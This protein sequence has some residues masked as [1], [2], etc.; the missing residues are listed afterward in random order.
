MNDTDYW[1]G[2][3]SDTNGGHTYHWVDGSTLSYLTYNNWGNNLMGK[4]EIMH[5]LF[6]S[7]VAVCMYVKV[8]NFWPCRDSQFTYISPRQVVHVVVVVVNDDIEFQ[9]YVAFPF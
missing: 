6:L 4:F 3:R 7:F 1:I 5:C 9:M 2:A 8:N